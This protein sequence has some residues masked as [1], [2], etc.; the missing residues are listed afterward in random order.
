MTNNEESL[1]GRTLELYFG[2]IPILSGTIEG[3]VNGEFTVSCQV[4]DFKT[5]ETKYAQVKI[6]PDDK[7]TIFSM[8]VHD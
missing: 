6:S 4:K 5:G 8:I 1:I 7:D 2:D 3:H